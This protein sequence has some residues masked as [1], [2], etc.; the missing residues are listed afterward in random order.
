[1]HS[2]LTNSLLKKNLMNAM[3][4]APCLPKL[5]INI[6]FDGWAE[7]KNEE[8]LIINVPKEIQRLLSCS[9]PPQT[10]YQQKLWRLEE[11]RK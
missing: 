1:M 5:L 9:I 7:L 6:N 10:S 11:E 3:C 2:R 8:E 4:H